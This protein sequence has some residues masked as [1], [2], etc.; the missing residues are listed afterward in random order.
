MSNR[1]ISDVVENNTPSNEDPRIAQ[2]KDL[3][4][5]AE[6]D[7][8]YRPLDKVIEMSPE[9][10]DNFGLMFSP[11]SRNFVLKSTD[12][13]PL[14]INSNVRFHYSTDPK[15]QDIPKV[16]VTHNRKIIGITYHK[17]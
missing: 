4:S 15:S 2:I 17:K 9:E 6:S 11:K 1:N 12:K 3:A 8:Q 10:M 5:A 14:G 13:N 16:G 7:K